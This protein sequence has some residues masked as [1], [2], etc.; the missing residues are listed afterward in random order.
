MNV[1]SETMAWA[2][3]YID[4]YGLAL[5]GAVFIGPAQGTVLMKKRDGAWKIVHEHISLPRKDPGE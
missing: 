4:N 5:D 2:T 1:V 3:L